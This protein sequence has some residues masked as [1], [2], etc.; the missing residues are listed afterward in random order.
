MQELP[1]V[2]ALVA[3]TGKLTCMCR[4]TLQMGAVIRVLH[5]HASQVNGLSGWGLRDILHASVVPLTNMCSI[6]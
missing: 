5:S 1:V 2:V 6:A 4:L 3:M